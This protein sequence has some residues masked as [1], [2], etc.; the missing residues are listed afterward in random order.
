MKKVTAAITAKA[1]P[2][3]TMVL[4]DRCDFFFLALFCDPMQS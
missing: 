4:P 2:Q 3:E 1:R